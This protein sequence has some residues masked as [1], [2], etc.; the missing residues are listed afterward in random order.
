MPNVWDIAESDFPHGSSIEAKI[1]FWLRYAILAPS[2]H[3]TQPWTYTIEENKLL[4]RRDPQHTLKVGDPTLRETFLGLGAFIENFCVA[5]AHWGYATEVT[6]FAFRTTD[7]PVATIHI[8]ESPSEPA[9]QAALFAGITKRHTNRGAYD[10][11]PLDALKTELE[12]TSEE[13]IKLFFIT[14]TEAKT[15][16]ATLVAK[17]T[18]IAL[19]MRPMKEELAELVTRQEEQASTGMTMEAMVEVSPTDITGKEWLFKRLDVTTESHQ[20]EI[21][22][23]QSPL[24]AVVGSEYDDPEAW[25]RAGRT[26]ERLLLA[27]SSCGLTHDISAAPVEVPPLAPQLRREIDQTYRPQVLLRLGKPKNPSFTKHSGRRSVA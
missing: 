4:V 3:N 27:A 13:G 17:G 5:A 9:K 7:D 11:E 16:I 18:R 23:R 14:D 24:M 8:S 20:N 19:S 25:L 15:R 22:W 2:A 12:I 26:M 10:P 1:K 21:N 6:D